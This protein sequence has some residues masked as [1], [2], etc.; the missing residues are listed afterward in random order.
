MPG[1]AFYLALAVTYGSFQSGNSLSEAQIRYLNY[2]GAKVKTTYAVPEKFL[3]KYS[4]RRSGYLILN[5][6]GTGTYHHDYIGFRKNGCNNGKIEIQ[7]GFI[8]DEKNKIVHFERPYGQSY[9]VLY[10]STGEGGFQDCTKTSFVDY[11]LEYQDGTI[12]VSSSDDWVK[13]E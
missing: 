4:G 12:T 7:W 1:I 3:G 13:I 2:E 8:V 9:P 11:I 5:S 10:F 6:D